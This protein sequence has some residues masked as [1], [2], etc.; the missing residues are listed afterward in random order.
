LNVIK[1]SLPPLRERTEDI[2][3]LAAHFLEKLRAMSTPP[4]TDID[5]AA[6]QALLDHPW[7]GNVRELEN[8]IKAAVAMADGTIIHR[9]ALPASIA[10]LPGRRTGPSL[11]DID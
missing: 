5:H 2:P 4:V 9:E 11:I 6:M 1:I 3:L 10:P 7:P 8:A